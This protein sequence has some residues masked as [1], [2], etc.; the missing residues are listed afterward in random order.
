V[1][2][3]RFIDLSI[4]I[5]GVF[6]A[7]QVLHWNDARVA[8][9][10]ADAMTEQLLAD[11]R[12]EA[13]I[14]DYII[15]YQEDVLTNADIAL[16]GFLGDAD[17]SN[18][19][20]FISAYRASQYTWWNQRRAA[21]DD[22]VSTGGIDLIKDARIRKLARSVYDSR[23][24]RDVELRGARSPYRQAYRMAIAT[25][26]HRAVS[27]ACGDGDS[28]MGD[29]ATLDGLLTYECALDLPQSEIDVAALALKEN[30]ALAP[31]LR[32]RIAT[33]ETQLAD[34]KE[35]REIRELFED[36]S[37]PLTP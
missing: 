20:L 3:R 16:R 21:F 35:S 6:I 14:Y 9:A 15:A 13:W 30:A 27:D 18:E 22:L 37:L 23:L 33:L 11:L 17:I 2:L 25:D 36:L 32:L 12:Q 28:K 1:L 4:V 31:A 5:S 7:I 29:Y 26:L 19:E 10:K 8:R 24:L 34:L